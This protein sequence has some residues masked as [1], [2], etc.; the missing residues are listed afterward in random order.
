[1]YDQTDH[2]IDGFF[3]FHPHL[4]SNVLFW[5]FFKNLTL[6]MTKLTVLVLRFS[7]FTDNSVIGLAL[8]K[9]KEQ[10]QLHLVSQ[11][12]KDILHLT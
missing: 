3:E 1:M 6:C 7:Y 12:S 5:R 2:Q 4:N 10:L 11:F 9:A 8:E